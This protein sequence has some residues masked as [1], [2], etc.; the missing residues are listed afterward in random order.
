MATN[1]TL[2][3]IV[4]NARTD[5]DRCEKT[6]AAMG[7]QLTPRG[8]HTLG[9][10]NALSIFTNDYLELLGLPPEQP[11][12]RPELAGAPL[13]LNGVVFK[14]ANAD[15]THAHLASLG[16]D[17]APPK[18]FSRPL[19]LA[20]GQE[21]NA[22][23]RTVTV[24]TETFPA[25][26]FYFC[27]HQTPELVW[28]SEWQDH[29]NGASG[30]AGLSVVTEQP[31]QDA[32]LTAAILGLAPSES[33][34]KADRVLMLNGGVTLT[35][36]QSEAYRARFGDFASDFS[37]RASA[38]AAVTI[39]A[40]WHDELPEALGRQQEAFQVRVDGSR[41]WIKVRIFNTLVI[42]DRADAM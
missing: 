36:E 4:I 31:D 22:C 6:F 26:R 12:V 9:S 30:F 27:E 2:D 10:I 34:N 39:N 28:R 20:D 3:H 21:H 19:T 33:G 41:I 16:I 40:T 13:G 42:L 17:A 18:S 25:G 32:A 5:M 11:N 14:T 8:H 35:F 37:G 15:E 24:P 38:L 23:F 29:K 7:F 1:A